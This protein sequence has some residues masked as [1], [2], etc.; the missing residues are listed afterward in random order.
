MKTIA[1]RLSMVFNLVSRSNVLSKPKLFTLHRMD[2]ETGVSGTGVVAWGVEWPDGAVSMRW[3]G[4][5]PSF[6]GYEGADAKE[7]TRRHGVEHAKRVH[8][9]H[10]KTILNWYGDNR[11]EKVVKQE[12]INSESGDKE[13][14]IT[15]WLKKT[16]LKFL[17]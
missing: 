4:A 6:V 2:D 10:G 15:R 9:H 17:Q 12:V 11:I 14:G 1:G 13:R 16:V 8:G 3:L 5:T 7:V